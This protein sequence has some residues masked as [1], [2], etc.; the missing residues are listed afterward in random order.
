MNL[1]DIQL[2]YMDFSLP[3]NREVSC[4]IVPKSGIVSATTNNSSG[5]VKFDWF[6]IK[7]A[8]WELKEK[9]Q[10]PEMVYML[11]THPKGFNRMSSIDKNMVYGWCMALAIPI[12][13]IVIT[14][15][16]ITTYFCKLNRETKRVEQEIVEPWNGCD[17]CPELQVI[18]ALMYGISK[19]DDSFNECILDDV[20]KSTVLSINGSDLFKT[21]DESVKKMF[22]YDIVK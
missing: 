7:E 20:V 5:S 6:T 11:H 17:D 21:F 4:F 14:E 3:F 22:S 13:F 9:N 19:I 15:E 10:C 18:A 16:E 8:I 2:K 12:T 1:V